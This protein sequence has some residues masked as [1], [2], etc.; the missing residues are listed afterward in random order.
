M[1]RGKQ[2]S[3]RRGTRNISRPLGAALGVSR[4]L[5]QPSKFRTQGGTGRR[6]ELNY[7]ASAS[8]LPRSVSTSRDPV[9]KGRER[10]YVAPRPH[11]QKPAIVGKRAARLIARESWSN[12]RVDGVTDVCGRRKRRRE[13]IHATGRAGSNVVRKLPK[14]TWRSLIKCKKG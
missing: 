9:V 11:L 8:A 1:S 3:N 6:R 7:L 4:T 5:S 10:F 13:V 14:Y 12:A 2:R